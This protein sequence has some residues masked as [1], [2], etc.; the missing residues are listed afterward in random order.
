VAGRLRALPRVGVGGGGAIMRRAQH[1]PGAAQIRAARSAAGLSQPAAAA[2]IG[3]TRR[4]WQDWEA[5]VSRM[6]P[7]I[8]AAWRAAVA[9]RTGDER[10]ALRYLRELPL[11]GD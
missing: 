1:H 7:A 4:T 11:S 5:G 8:W 3:S 9:L 10:S 2:L 6:H